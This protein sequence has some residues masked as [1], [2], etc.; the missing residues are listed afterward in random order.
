MTASLA[1]SFDGVSLVDPPF[2]GVRS[3]DGVWSTPEV[4]TS[5]AM[6]SRNHGLWA[7]VDLLGGRSISASLQ[8]AATHPNEAQYAL[9]QG[10]LYPTGDERLLTLQLT[11]FAGGQPVQTF[12][13]VRRLDVPVTVDQYAKGHPAVEVQW[14]ATDPRWYAQTAT[15]V[16][17]D[18]GGGSGV[19]MAFDAGFDLEFGGATP[20]GVVNV[21]NDGT[22]PAPF[23]LEVSGAVS[24]LRVENVTTGETLRF[25]GTPSAGET[26]VVESFSR[27]VTINGA[28]RY[29]WLDPGSQWFDLLPGPNQLRVASSSGAGVG[30]LT[31]RSAWI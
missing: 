30:T 12:A 9:I 4:R 13:R 28:S 8:V 1:M 26:L 22:F 5:D 23:T 15:V 11:G 16:S 24:N 27:Q 3:L 31:F 14:F 10:L 25:T 7:G 18:V 6:R 21:N 2:M 17:T 20:S 29:S 19:G